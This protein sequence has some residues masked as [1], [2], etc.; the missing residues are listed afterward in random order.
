MLCFN[1]LYLPIRKNTAANYI[2]YLMDGDTQCNYYSTML[3]FYWDRF[4]PITFQND[5]NRKQNLYTYSSQIIDS[6]P[7]IMLFTEF[8]IVH[9]ILVTN[10]RMLT[11][12]IS[13]SNLK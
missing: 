7:R 12:A 9:I 13:I 2:E 11:S 4:T 1:F 10:V 6:D 8:Y 3:V 5:L